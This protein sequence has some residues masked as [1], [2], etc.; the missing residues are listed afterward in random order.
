MQPKSIA[1]RARP[2]AGL[3]VGEAH[4]KVIS[5]Q[6]MQGPVKLTVERTYQ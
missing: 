6:V 3:M 4:A 2:H 1:W 5:L